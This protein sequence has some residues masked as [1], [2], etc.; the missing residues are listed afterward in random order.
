M[1]LSGSQTSAP[2]PPL[3]LHQPRITMSKWTSQLST[4]A[5][6]VQRAHQ[7]RSGCL[8]PSI[9][10][11]MCLKSMTSH[12]ANYR[13]TKRGFPLYL[14]PFLSFYFGV[15]AV[16]RRSISTRAHV[17]RE[18]RNRYCLLTR[19]PVMRRATT[20]RSESWPAR[21]RAAAAPST[22]TATRARS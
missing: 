4:S 21:Q 12:D 22:T 16:T 10:S 19:E 9:H 6:H 7:Y 1:Q 18:L 17:T 2:Q 3:L 13:C 11:S 8:L 5:L 20:S 15:G 14:S